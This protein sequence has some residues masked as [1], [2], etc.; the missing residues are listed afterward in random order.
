MHKVGFDIAAMP[1][2]NAKTALERERHDRG[3]TI[4]KLKQ[5]LSGQG[6]MRELPA[7]ERLSRAA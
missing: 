2:G 3:L 5:Q 1:Y 7:L 6:R 4:Y